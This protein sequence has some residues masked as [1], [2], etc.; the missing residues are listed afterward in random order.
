MALRRVFWVPPCIFCVALGYSGPVPEGE[1]CFKKGP[2]GQK[3]YFGCLNRLEVSLHCGPLSR[4][5][6]TRKVIAI[7][8]EIVGL[9]RRA[10]VANEKDTENAPESKERWKEIAR[11]TGGLRKTPYTR[12]KFS[13]TMLNGLRK[14]QGLIRGA[15]G[16]V[17]REKNLLHKVVEYKCQGDLKWDPITKKCV[18]SGIYEKVVTYGTFPRSLTEQLAA[19]SPI[20]ANSLIHTDYDAVSLVLRAVGDARG[21][22]VVDGDKTDSPI[23]ER[24]AAARSSR[25][26]SS[27]R[28]IEQP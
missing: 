22:G 8:E 10:R 17:C 20:G 1:T 25:S 3:Q 7:E 21:V 27:L 6:V 26:R 15:A 12:D 16:A 11:I 19:V 5:C 9:Y 13:S 18:S 24:L 28:I 14:I 2:K 23:A 4:K